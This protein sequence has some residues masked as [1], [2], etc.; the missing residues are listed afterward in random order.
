MNLITIAVYRINLCKI[1]E[2]G[3]LRV[4]D[5]PIAPRSNTNTPLYLCEEKVPDAFAATQPL[6]IYIV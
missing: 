4:P 3:R 1:A 2:P 6:T 5:K